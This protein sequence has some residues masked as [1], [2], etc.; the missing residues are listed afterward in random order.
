[1]IAPPPD[2]PAPPPP[3]APQAQLALRPLP[4]VPPPPREPLAL[5]APPADRV[6]VR[7][8]P[9][10]GEREVFVPGVRTEPEPFLQKPLRALDLGF[11][12]DM[13]DAGVEAIISFFNTADE[14]IKTFNLFPE[15]EQPIMIPQTIRNFPR[16]GVGTDFGLDYA[17]RGMA[18]LATFLVSQGENEVI[19]KIPE[20]D[21]NYARLVKEVYKGSKT[22][23]GIYKYKKSLTFQDTLQMTRDRVG[24]ATLVGGGLHYLLENILGLPTETIVRFPVGG[25]GDITPDQAIEIMEN[26]EENLQAYQADF[27]EVGANYFRNNPAIREL[28]VD[29]IEMEGLG[30]PERVRAL[31][32]LDPRDDRRRFET[33]FGRPERTFD[34]NFNFL[35]RFPFLRYSAEA[36]RLNQVNTY[37]RD[38]I[39]GLRDEI[40]RGEAR[41]GDFVLPSVGRNDMLNYFDAIVSR[42]RQLRAP[43]LGVQDPG[44]PPPP[45]R[46][47]RP[48][49]LPQQIQELIDL[50]NRGREI[51]GE[52]EYSMD[53][54]FR[55]GSMR[56]PVLGILALVEYFIFTNL[57]AMG[58]DRGRTFMHPEQMAYD[59][60]YKNFVDKD[61]ERP[62][63]LPKINYYVDGDRD[64]FVI[65]GTKGLDDVIEDFMVGGQFLTAKTADVLSKPFTN[66][67][68]YEPEMGN[69]IAQRKKM[70][71]IE[72]FIRQNAR[73]LSKTTV[74]GHSLGTIEANILKVRMPEI[75]AVGF[76]PGIIPAP[77]VDRAYS[78]NIDPLYYQTGLANHKVIKKV[79][80]I[81]QGGRLEQGHSIDNFI[82]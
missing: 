28:L 41:V 27:R 5:P 48:T 73:D 6:E 42:I 38:F 50:T 62:M 77:D 17:L 2:V 63:P 58:M 44:D 82:S 13:G 3:Q 16:P 55:R 7:N 78:I 54:I 51:L 11:I 57:R 81:N 9:L 30:I 56:T 64:I 31:N 12:S 40:I 15:D 33:P 70:R 36:L 46:F 76:S 10:I 67:G 18:K 21:E 68:I 75:E 69:A 24:L 65:R 1:M 49:L 71:T 61:Y 53:V 66:K 8:L 80:D 37:D 39:N 59:S 14:A 79:F 74:V 25:E 22:D 20:V 72:N 35:Q 34:L 29:R 43:G 47:A 19:E 45:I 4:P 52:E 32:P 26:E 60:F 23:F